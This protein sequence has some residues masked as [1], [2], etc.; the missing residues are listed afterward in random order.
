MKNE[1]EI[2]DLFQLYA[3]TKARVLVARR[4]A[5]GGLKDEAREVAR[6]VRNSRIIEIL[7]P[8]EWPEHLNVDIAH[9]A[10]QVGQLE[11]ECH[12]L[13]ADTFP[14]DDIGKIYSLLETIAR[15]MEEHFRG[16]GV[17]DPF[18]GPSGHGCPSATTSAP[19]KISAVESVE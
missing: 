3:F 5:R 14:S 18:I 2:L 9:F 19:Q 11:T 13:N 17:R 8:V 16:V 10:W 7:R 15:R 4:Q 12:P 6:F 1:T